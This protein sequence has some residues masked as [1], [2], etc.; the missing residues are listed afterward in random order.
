MVQEQYLER[1]V[2][3]PPTEIHPLGHRDITELRCRKAEFLGREME[4]NGWNE[5]N[6]NPLLV[7]EIPAGL[8]KG[9]LYQNGCR[10]GIATGPDLEPYW[11]LYA[12]YLSHTKVPVIV[13]F[14]DED[15]GELAK[16]F[17]YIMVVSHPQFISEITYDDA[18]AIRLVNT[19][20]YL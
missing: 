16:A 6:E 10:Y 12:A 5:K 3:I 2:L 11:K 8:P 19:N 4:E 20:G 18:H 13:V 7:Y 15:H 17:E 14:P 9:T 1:I